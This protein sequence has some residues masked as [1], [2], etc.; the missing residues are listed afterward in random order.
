[1][2]PSP[3]RKSDLCTLGGLSLGFHSRTPSPDPTVPLL[4]EEGEIVKLL[5]ATLEQTVSVPL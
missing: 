4:G 3:R 5:R 2:G 1:M